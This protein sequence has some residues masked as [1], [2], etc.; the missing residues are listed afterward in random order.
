[1]THEPSNMNMMA[2]RAAA[3]TSKISAQAFG[4][5]PFEV[6]AP[7]FKSTLSLSCSTPPGTRGD[8]VGLQQEDTLD[9]RDT[10]KVYRVSA[11]RSRVARK[12]M[13]LPRCVMRSQR[14]ARRQS[15]FDIRAV[16]ANPKSV[17]SSSTMVA[18][19]APESTARTLKI[20]T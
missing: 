13:S 4:V 7:V 6:D 10:A 12:A 19:A 18:P 9:T 8:V 20:S 11:R 17:R 5:R 14:S 2:T 1:M 15:V 3:R 16:V